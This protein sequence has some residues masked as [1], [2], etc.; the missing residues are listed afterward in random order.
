MITADDSGIQNGHRAELLSPARL[1]VSLS[2]SG[3]GEAA[4]P[5]P[6]VENYGLPSIL[7]AGLEISA[8]YIPA[9]GDQYD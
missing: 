5:P 3:L 4:R 8:G 2:D 6:V 7:L 1:P 9:D